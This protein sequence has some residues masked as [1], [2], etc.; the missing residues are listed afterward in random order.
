MKSIDVF[1][2][3]VRL[4]VDEFY[5]TV[6]QPMHVYHSPEELHENEIKDSDV[7]VQ[8]IENKT[9]FFAFTDTFLSKVVKNQPYSFIGQ[10]IFL[11]TCDEYVPDTFD[12]KH[13]YSYKLDENGERIP[14]AG[15]Y[16]RLYGAAIFTNKVIV[17]TSAGKFLISIVEYKIYGGTKTNFKYTLNPFLVDRPEGS[18]DVDYATRLK[19]ISLKRKPDINMTRAVWSLLNPNAPNFMDLAQTLKI[20]FK[21][22]RVADRHVVLQTQAFQKAL[23]MALKTLYPDLKKAVKENIKPEDLVAFLQTMMTKAADKSVDDMIKVFDKITEVGYAEQITYGGGVDM[24]LPP[25]IPMNNSLPAIDAAKKDIESKELEEELNYPKSYVQNKVN[26]FL[27]D[28]FD[29]DEN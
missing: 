26:S 23:I 1:D 10:K 3:N 15:V 27:D 19:R 16:V 9:E 2:P 12:V 13:G 20:H 21:T 4:Q 6:D 8:V 11:R 17:Y 24:I 22:I 29:I 25:T 28:E 5:I 14:T 7:P 18:R